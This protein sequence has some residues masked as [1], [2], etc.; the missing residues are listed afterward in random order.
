MGE[1]FGRAFYKAASYETAVNGFRASGL[2]FT[3]RDFFQE[4]DFFINSKCKDEEKIPEASKPVEITVLDGLSS[5]FPL[6]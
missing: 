1:I 2:F 6:I 4:A 5:I 3:N